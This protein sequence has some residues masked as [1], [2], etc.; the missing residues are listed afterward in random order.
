[1]SQVIFQPL[2][3][4]RRRQ[5][6]CHICRVWSACGK[7]EGE[8]R[9]SRD[10]RDGNIPPLF[11]LLSRM[12][13]TW[14]SFFFF[15]FFELCLCQPFLSPC[16]PS[17]LTIWFTD[18]TALPEMSVKILSHPDAAW[19]PRSVRP[20]FATTSRQTTFPDK[21]LG[22][23]NRYSNNGHKS[24]KVHKSVLTI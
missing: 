21:R 22:N 15:F 20:K 12:R 23:I 1:M 5:S 17:G 6:S 7:K 19:E 4:L 14:L 11:P 9:A 10:Y 3:T 16:Q 2:S 18:T 13:M 8:Q 24:I